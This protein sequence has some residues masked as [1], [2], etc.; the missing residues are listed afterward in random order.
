MEPPMGYLSNVLTDKGVCLHNNNTGNMGGIIALKKNIC[1]AAALH[2]LSAD[3]EY[4]S[5]FIRQYLP[6][7][8]I[9][10]IGIAAA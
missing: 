2:A 1:H 8:N 5:P 4:N 6:D 3:G 9:Q 7:D 10:M